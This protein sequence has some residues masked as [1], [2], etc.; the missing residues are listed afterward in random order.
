[1]D[2]KLQGGK[3]VKSIT[4]LKKEIR[5]FVNSGQFYILAV[6]FLIV[7]GWAFV[8]RLF[9]DNLSSMNTVFALIPYIIMVFIPLITMGSFASEKENGTIEFLLTMP[10]KD[11]DIIIGK[12][13]A[14]SFIYILIIAS[15]F[16]YPLTLV[17]L[18]NPDM[19]QII[20]GYFGV[21]LLGMA[22]ISAGLFASSITNNQ[23]SGFII[24]FIIT[25][26]SIF[27]G[28]LAHFFPGIVGSIFNFLSIGPHYNTMV[29]G[30]VDTK[31][32][33]YFVSY[34]VLFLFLIKIS[35]ES[36]KW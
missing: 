16:M 26:V 25:L 28:R 32:I 6:G 33:L 23:I 20:S 10:F 1:M 2:E 5:D 35:L 18:G 8:D 14:M 4:L 24:G 22:F 17:L 30:L 15:T 19:G 29:N 21:T 7:M 9:I 27:V 34:I 31:N 12:F 36:R 11:W 13:A 3:M